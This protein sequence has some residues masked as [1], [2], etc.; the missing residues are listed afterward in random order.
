MKIE[1]AG[2]KPPDIKRLWEQNP[3]FNIDNPTTTPNQMQP[4][5]PPTLPANN[6]EPDPLDMAGINPSPN[7]TNNSPQVRN[8]YLNVFGGDLP[9][10]LEQKIFGGDGDEK[11]EEE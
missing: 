3:D 9:E 7:G 4:Q 11:R 8:S 5:K 6:T 2:A 1:S 10:W